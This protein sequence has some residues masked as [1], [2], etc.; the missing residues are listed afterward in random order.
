[1][2]TTSRLISNVI[3]DRNQVNGHRVKVIQSDSGLSNAI[4]NPYRP[5]NAGNLVKFMFM[6][7]RRKGYAPHHPFAVY[8]RQA[9]KF[10]EEVGCDRAEELMLEAAYKAKH[11]WG[12]NF[13]RRLDVNRSAKH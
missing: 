6:L 3:L 5:V 2:L 1:M 8:L 10:I 9:K 11:A 7:H 4:E 13:V 12:F